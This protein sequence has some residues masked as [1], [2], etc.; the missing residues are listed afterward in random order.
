MEPKRKILYKD[1]LSSNLKI[2]KFVMLSA[3]AVTHLHV[4]L[5]E[6][7]GLRTVVYAAI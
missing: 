6:Y 1:A 7:S 5:F 3:I 2:N 4:K